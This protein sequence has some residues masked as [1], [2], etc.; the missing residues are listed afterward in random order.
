[1]RAWA[2]TLASHKKGH[3]VTRMQ[4]SHPEKQRQKTQ[5]FEVHSGLCDE[6]EA[7]PGFRKPCQNKQ[8]QDKTRSTP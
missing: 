3:D 5:K 7:S 8:K 6:F 2:Q 1:M 4:S